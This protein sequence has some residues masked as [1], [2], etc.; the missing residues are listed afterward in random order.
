MQNE[1]FLTTQQAAGYTKLAV[2]TLTKKRL[3]G[4]GPAFVKIGRRVVYRRQDL[5]EWLERHR[6][7]ST[8]DVGEVGR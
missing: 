5:D 7:M 6:R 1:A 8:S 2:S 4:E 3:T